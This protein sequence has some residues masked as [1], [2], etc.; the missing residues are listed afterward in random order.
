MDLRV[1]GGFG[2]VGVSQ[3]PSAFLI[4]GRTLL[5]AGTVAGAL[6]IPEQ[7]AI[8]HALISHVHLDHTAGLAFLAETLALI[9]E[10][11]RHGA[12]RPLAV[13]STP[14]V[15]EGLQTAVFNNTAWPDFSR[16]PPEGPV[17][18]YGDLAEGRAHRVGDLWVTPIAVEHTIPTCGFIIHDGHTGL[19]YSADTGPTSTIWQATRACASLGA[20]ILEC[21]FPNRL[22]KLA[23]VAGHL[24]PRLIEREL[25]KLPPD[26]PVWI[27]HIKA[28]FF[29]ETGEELARIHGASRLVLLEQ[30]KTYTL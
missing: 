24:T 16:I 30:G 11:E 28:P 21:S 10:A 2:S 9:N 4:N 18:S 5:D 25:D 6:T 8:E 22:D 29:E 14:P 26:V 20:I 3:R 15:V 19:A 17:L 1:L 12:P 23:E 7:L 27:F 13:L